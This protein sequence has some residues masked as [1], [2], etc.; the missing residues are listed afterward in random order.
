MSIRPF[1]RTGVTIC[2]LVFGSVLVSAK[3]L[4][5]LSSPAGATVELEGEVVGTTPFER[6]FPSGYFQ[7]PMTILQ[8]RL[9]HPIHLRLTLAGYI[10]QEILL[11][12]GPKDWLDLHRRSH[13]Q[14]WLFKS[15]EFHIDLPA[16]P[17]ASEPASMRAL[18]TPGCQ[19]PL[20]LPAPTPCASIA[21]L[22][23]ADQGLFR[24]S[25]APLAGTQVGPR[26]PFQLGISPG[27]GPRLLLLL[28]D[29]RV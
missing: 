22:R 10:T 6:D 9:E 27:A 19:C 25:F 11:T 16:L 5:I 28:A 12:L 21:S 23:R 2:L 3:T 4:K 14:Y 24:S 1:F 15:D 13:G 29:R 7:R 17:P 8:K 20:P 26:S 18:E